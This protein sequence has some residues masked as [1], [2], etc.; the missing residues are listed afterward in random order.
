MN[1]KQSGLLKTLSRDFQM[2][3]RT[4]FLALMIL[5]LQGCSNVPLRGTGDLGVVIERA[6]GSIEVVE[7]SGR[8][9]LGKVTGLGD[10]SHASVNYSRDGRY[11]Y[12][13]GRD[14][15]L[16]K[17]DLLAMRV[18]KRVMQSGNSI[19]GAI[20]QDGKLVAVANYT[21]GGIK[22]FDSATLDLVADIPSLDDA[23][24][25]SKVVGLVDAPGNRFVWCLFEAGEIWVGDFKS[26]AKPV[27]Q[28]FKHIGKE[29]YDAMITADGRYYLAGLFGEDGLA[30]LDL[31]NPDAGVKQVLNHYGKGEQKLPV[32]KMPHME[33]WA[34]TGNELLVPAVGRH[35]VL[36]IDENSW[37]EVAH[38]PVH[39]QPVFVVARPD[40][41]QVWVNFAFPDNDTVQIIDVP[42][43]KIVQSINPG[44]AVLHMEFTPR[45]E[46]VWVSARDD[47]KV[48][49]YDS[50]TY[51]VQGELHIDS[52][53]GIFFTHRAN[54]TGL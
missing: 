28:K 42:S 15:G 20:S 47:N 25:S 54:R 33:G 1:Q 50:E 52:P 37:Q 10:L 51:A 11:A 32:F 8:S 3:N 48:T 40:N 4:S 6:T 18:V 46:S 7:T 44:K 35:E 26:P 2:L 30:L 29:P 14:G 21:P 17:V 16:T 43:R 13:F 27:L 36:V 5:T 45:G 22:V 23:G 34:A 39:G 38:I 9:V 53:S 31:W 24:K 49:I 12:I 41:R 19:G